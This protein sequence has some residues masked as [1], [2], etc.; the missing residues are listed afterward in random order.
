MDTSKGAGS[1]AVTCYHPRMRLRLFLF[2]QIPLPTGTEA[3]ARGV[4][5][6]ASRSRLALIHRKQAFWYALSVRGLSSIRPAVSSHW[7]QAPLALLRSV[8]F[9][10]RYWV[11]RAHSSRKNSARLKPRRRLLRHEEVEVHRGA[12]RVRPEASGVGDEC[13]AVSLCRRGRLD[14]FDARL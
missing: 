3:W 12:D 4:S 10:E 6:L 13:R 7:F 9:T 11:L 2:S 1:Q 8:Q 14:A 5:F